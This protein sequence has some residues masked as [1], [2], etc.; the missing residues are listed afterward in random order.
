MDVS[1]DVVA[2]VVVLVHVL[3]DV[4]VDVDVVGFC[5]RA[6]PSL[7]EMTGRKPVLRP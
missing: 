2:V 3:V 5:R 1:V 4:L 6:L 7:K